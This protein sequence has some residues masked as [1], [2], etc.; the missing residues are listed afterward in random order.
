[1]SDQAWFTPTPPLP[2]SLTIQSLERAAAILNA[3]PVPKDTTIWTPDGLHH[4][5]SHS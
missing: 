4:V 5:S 1:M 2:K 3:A